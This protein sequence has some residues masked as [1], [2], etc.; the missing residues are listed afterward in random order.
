MYEKLHDPSAAKQERVTSILDTDRDLVLSILGQLSAVTLCTSAAVCKTW[1]DVQAENTGLLWLNLMRADYPLLPDDMLQG[2]GTAHFIS[3]YGANKHGCVRFEAQVINGLKL[4]R[5]NFGS[6]MWGDVAYQG[7][8]TMNMLNE[9]F[10][11]YDHYPLDANS[12][13]TLGVPPSRVR[14]PVGSKDFEVP[15]ESFT[16][17]LQVGMVVELQ[18]KARET[19]PRFLWWFALVHQVKGPDEVVV[20]FPQYGRLTAMQVRSH[21]LRR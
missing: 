2:P 10:K 4:K 17:S 12:Y 11:G 6:A 19:S 5:G 18:W 3:F 21:P 20:F 14:R 16:T 9:D 1:K 8:H 13:K 15:L 7:P